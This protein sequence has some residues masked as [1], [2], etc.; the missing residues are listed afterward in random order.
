MSSPCFPRRFMET[1]G[2]SAVFDG[3]YGT[4]LLLADSRPLQGINRENSCIFGDIHEYKM[5]LAGIIAMGFG[6]DFCG[7]KK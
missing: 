4:F 5:V 7:R 2:E 3:R 1:P 6:V